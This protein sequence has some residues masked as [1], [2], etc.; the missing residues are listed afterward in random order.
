[1]KN[2]PHTEHTDTVPS[3]EIAIPVEETVYTPAAQAQPDPSAAPEEPES[4]NAE[5]V[6]K[7]EEQVDFDSLLETLRVTGHGVPTIAVKIPPESSLLDDDSLIF[8]VSPDPEKDGQNGEEPV[9]SPAISDAEFNELMQ[10]FQPRQQSAAQLDNPWA[11]E[12]KEEE[13]PHSANGTDM[14][15]VIEDSSVLHDMQQW[16]KQLNDSIV[17]S[18]KEAAPNSAATTEF[19]LLLQ[20]LEQS[21][22]RRDEEAQSTA[23]FD[24]PAAASPAAR[25]AQIPDVPTPAKKFGGI[26]TRILCTA[27]AVL[28]ICAAGL[29]VLGNTVFR[30]PGSAFRERAVTELHSHAITRWI[31]A[32]FLTQDE[33]R[34]ILTQAQGET[35]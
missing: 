5:A 1:M 19:D 30:G 25:A 28:I 11:A 15:Q 4:P 22:K 26:L 33:I 23:V 16:E 12:E 31:P 27:L 13:A 9:A 29:L 17:Q 3:R 14:P 18:Q 7:S 32:V 24:S 21:R 8:S 35:E 10:M 2:H 34:D 20:N 6:Q